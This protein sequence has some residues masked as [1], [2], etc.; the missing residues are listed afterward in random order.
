LLPSWQVSWG[1]WSCTA[2][3]WIGQQLPGS[4]SS[5]YALWKVSLR[6][7]QWILCSAYLLVVSWLTEKADY[8]LP[9][10]SGVFIWNCP[11][12]IHHLCLTWSNFSVSCKRFFPLFLKNV[13][14]YLIA[15][16][17]LQIRP[18][19]KSQDIVWLI[20]CNKMKILDI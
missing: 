2:N 14:K 20:I 5:Y 11:S 15:L 7:G 6:V 10:K 9:W 18:W 17:L 8:L 4:A 3:R 16:M 12:A 19:T 13:I 1:A